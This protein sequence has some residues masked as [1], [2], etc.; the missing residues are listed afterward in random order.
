MSWPQYQRG[1][2]V[3]DGEQVYLTPT[4]TEILSVLLIRRGSVVSRDELW[5]LVW[6]DPDDAPD[7]KNIDVQ[8]CKLRHRIGGVI[9]NEWGRGYRVPL[10]GKEADRLHCHDLRNAA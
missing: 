7:A 4:Q 2:C 3:V 8:V 10:P 5:E 9:E 1:C 6:P